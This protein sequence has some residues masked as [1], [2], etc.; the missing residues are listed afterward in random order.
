MLK[1]SASKIIANQK[2]IMWKGLLICVLVFLLFST[3]IEAKKFEK[4]E[5]LV[6]D[7]TC[8]VCVILS[9]GLIHGVARERE[10]LKK[11]LAQIC[12]LIPEGNYRKT[13]KPKF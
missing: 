7:F 11:A 13:V 3:N 2:S 6:L 9:N 1:K 12:N 10:A 5:P 4:S 8:T